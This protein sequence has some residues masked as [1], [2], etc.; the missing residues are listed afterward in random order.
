MFLRHRSTGSPVM[1]L[2]VLWIT[3][4]ILLV[5]K[6]WR[7][8]RH[9]QKHSNWNRQSRQTGLVMLIFKSNSCHWIMYKSKITISL[10]MVRIVMV[11]ITSRPWISE[12]SNFGIFFREIKGCTKLFI[13][14]HVWWWIRIISKKF[15]SIH[16][17]CL[18]EM[19]SRITSVDQGF[20]FWKLNQGC[21]QV[22]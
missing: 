22:C 7:N 3:P 15:S 1:G 17:L 12:K 16:S 5:I 14:G 11:M 10:G 6:S 2:F 20:G 13:P 8:L 21:F 9:V 4:R 19:S 18:H